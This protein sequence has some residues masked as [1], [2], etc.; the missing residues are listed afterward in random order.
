MQDILCPMG[1]LL[2]EVS[3]VSVVIG[4]LYTLVANRPDSSRVTKTSKNTI[5]LPCSNYHVNCMSGSS[6]FNFVFFNNNKSI[7]DVSCQELRWALG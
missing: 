3:I 2:P 6:E 4:F 5:W 7:I 1:W